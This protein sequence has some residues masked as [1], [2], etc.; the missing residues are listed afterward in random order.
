MF[1][2]VRSL[3]RP[4]GW[5]QRARRG[6]GWPMYQHDRRHTGRSTALGPA[7]GQVAWYYPPGGN[8][9]LTGP[10]YNFTT[11]PVVGSGEAIY[12]AGLFP[13]GGDDERAAALS[14]NGVLA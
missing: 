9:A 12:V 2:R 8:G 14:P 11:S 10:A 3:A 4:R 1:A 6:A 5:V 7:L 13:N